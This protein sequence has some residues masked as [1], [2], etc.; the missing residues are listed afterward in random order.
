MKYT[1]P[2]P[3]FYDKLKTKMDIFVHLVYRFTEEF[4]KEEV[5]GVTLQ[6]R[7]ALLSVILNY[8]EG[9]ARK[10]EKSYKHFLEISYTSLKEIKYIFHLSLV[11]KYVT[12]E[13]YDETLVLAEAIGAMLWNTMK[14]I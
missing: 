1:K 11:E 10:R 7:F 14:K 12:K 2:M 5:Y 13:Q 4:P 6:V 9:F 8:I 3:Q